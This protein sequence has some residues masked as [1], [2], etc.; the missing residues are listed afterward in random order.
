MEL[1]D[2]HGYAQGGARTGCRL[3]G[4]G[5]REGAPALISGFMVRAKGRGGGSWSGQRRIQPCQPFSPS[6]FFPHPSQVVLKPAELTPLTAIALAE[7]AGRWAMKGERGGPS[8]VHPYIHPS[9]LGTG[10][11]CQMHSPPLSDVHPRCFF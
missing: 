2:E 11:A 3:H 1:P 7:L 8:D 10:R 4:E 6:S 5:G 9:S